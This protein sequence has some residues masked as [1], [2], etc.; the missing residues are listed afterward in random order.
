[1]N[2]GYYSI[3]PANVR[4]DKN[5]NA[6]TKLFYAE[7]T[8]LANEKGYCWASNG[9]FANLYGVTK[10]TISVWIKLLRDKE[11]IKTKIE[12]FEGTRN[13]KRRLIFINN[14][15]LNDFGNQ[16]DDDFEEE[17][18]ENDL[19]NKSDEVSNKSD[20]LSNKSD[21]PI[22]KNLK[23]NN[24]NEY[25]SINNINNKGCGENQKNKNADE[26]ALKEI[27]SISKD[28]GIQKAIKDFAGND[29]EM[30]DALKEFYK[31]R[32]KLKKPLTARALKLNINSLKDLSDDR[33]EQIAI[34]D[35]SIQK[36]WQSFYALK[37]D[38]PKKKKEGIKYGYVF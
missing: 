12:Y 21:D 36:G 28:K 16:N 13:I 2:R 7:L 29:L 34:I 30:I 25:Y 9:Y 1:M 32:S 24:I 20:T 3:L 23:E 35:Q 26:E 19:S 15:F 6:S 33:D 14:N 11:Y 8:A 27:K 31:A 37:D 4:Y 38:N 5:L 22:K 18:E 10:Q 17:I